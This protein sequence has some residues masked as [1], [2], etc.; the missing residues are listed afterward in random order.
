MSLA[1]FFI[2]LFVTF[3]IKTRPF[4]GKPKEFVSGRGAE[5]G[6]LGAHRE[7]VTSSSWLRALYAVAS[8]SGMH[9]K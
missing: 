2:C 7:Q 6:K 4:Y 5:T 1:L 3:L 8:K 9:C